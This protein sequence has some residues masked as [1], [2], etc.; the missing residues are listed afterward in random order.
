M[1]AD[2]AKSAV[3]IGIDIGGTFTDLVLMRHG[4]VV[5]TRKVSST[6]LDYSDGICRGVL[7]ILADNELSAGDVS[8]IVHATTVATNAILEGKG[9]LTGLI[10]TSGFRDV[11]EFRRVRVPELYNLDYVKPRPLATR[12]FRMEVDERLAPDGSIR[13]PLDE[14]SV[15]TAAHR[16]KDAGIEAVAICLLHSYANPAHEQRVKEIVR[17]VCGDKV[18]LTCSFEILPEMREY[19]RTSTTVINAFLGPLMNRYLDTLRSRLAAIGLSC[20]IHVMTS[21]GGQMTAEAAAVKPVCVIESGPAAGVIAAARIALEAGT[22]NV[23]TLDM[24][25][26]TAK[27]AIVENG[28]PTKTSEF[29]IGGGINLSSQLVK[30]AGYAVRL[31]FIDVS[32]I[33]AGGGSHVWF[34]KGGL[35]KVGPT[36]AASEPGPVCYGKGGKQA[37]LT[38]VLLTLGYINPDFLAGGSLALNAGLAREAVQRQIAEPLGK[39]MHEAAYGAF[40]VAIANMVRAVKSVSTY[41]GRD[42]RD[43]TLLAFGGN[44]P[45]TVAAIA[46][47]LQIKHILVPPNS[48]VLSAYGLLRA[49]HEEELTQAVPGALATI[50]PDR[51]ARAFASLIARAVETHLAAG[52]PRQSID[53]RCFG[54][55]RYVGQ[56]FELTVPVDDPAAPDVAQ[57]AARFHAEHKRTYGHMAVNEPVELVNIRIIARVAAE[58]APAT[59]DSKRVRN[60]APVT[61][62][63]P[64][65]D[66]YF[67][68]EAGLRPTAIVR[69]PDI[70][71][72]TLAGP[73]IVEDYD[74][75]C[76]VPPDATVTV[77]EMANLRITMGG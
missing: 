8:D 57:L 28:E 69:R 72:R 47:E 31:P 27:T 1:T 51:I 55:L 18:F 68:R 20:P 71:G 29:E 14:G 64:M 9:A 49:D 43:Y 59:G 61:G 62:A 30:G 4:A 50:L 74:S 33:G 34:D 42:P 26:T 58:G 63:F 5:A 6:P 13:V 32:E 2:K 36:S 45:M 12:R 67:G 77:D 37:T 15:R 56:A 7:E 39:S 52:F 44:G 41:R 19:E 54:D 76:L 53:I 48:G 70:A 23:I 65:R 40:Q 60:A 3:R 16:L 38:D 17:E 66:A 35:M 22:P 73:V 10:T 25:G 75:T 24:G 11:L 46:A 21:G